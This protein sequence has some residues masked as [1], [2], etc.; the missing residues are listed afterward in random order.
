MKKES[1]NLVQS[2]QF[3]SSTTQDKTISN[4]VLNSGI[5]I[6]NKATLKDTS[7]GDTLLTASILSNEKNHD[8]HEFMQKFDLKDL[9][10][11]TDFNSCSQS[12]LELTKKISWGLDVS[13]I[14]NM[15]M[16]TNSEIVLGDTQNF[17]KTFD[18]SQLKKTF[19]SLKKVDSGNDITD[20][21]NRK[22]LSNS[23]LKGNVQSSFSPNRFSKSPSRFNK[24]DFDRKKSNTK[25]SPVNFSLNKTEKLNQ[26]MNSS[27]LTKDLLNNPESI[28]SEND[29]NSRILTD[30]ILEKQ[31]SFTKTQP[32]QSNSPVKKDNTQNKKPSRRILDI[33]P[34]HVYVDDLVQNSPDNIEELTKA[35][36]NNPRV[37]QT[38]K[39]VD[40]IHHYDTDGFVVIDF[41]QSQNNLNQVMVDSMDFA[42]LKGSLGN[43]SGLKES[44]GNDSGL[45]ES[46]DYSNIIQNINS[47]GKVSDQEKP[48]VFNYATGTDFLGADFNV[49]NVDSEIMDTSDV[50]E[51]RQY[52]CENEDLPNY[53]IPNKS[54]SI[55]VLENF[56]RNLLESE[57]VAA[58][59]NLPSHQTNIP[60]EDENLENSM[61]SGAFKSDRLQK[62]SK[63]EAQK[64][65]Q[66]SL[67]ISKQSGLGITAVDSGVD[68]NFIESN[69][70]NDRVV[71]DSLVNLDAQLINSQVEDNEGFVIVKEQTKKEEKLVQQQK[72]EEE[73]E[74]KFIKEEKNRK[75]QEKKRKEDQEKKR[76]QAEEKK[77]KEDQEKKRKQ[78]DQIQFKLEEEEKKRKIE[79][80]K[81]QKMDEDRQ[82]ADRYQAKQRKIE[83]ED[84]KRKLEE[85]KIRVEE[86]VKKRK[87][88]EE[89][90]RKEDQEK[91]RKLEDEKKRVDEE[92]NHKEEEQKKLKKEE[93][94]KRLEEGVKKRLEEDEKKLNKQREEKKLKKGSP[95][96]KRKA[97]QQN[98]HKDNCNQP[99]NVEYHSKADHAEVEARKVKETNENL[100]RDVEKLEQALEIQR[101]N[102]EEAAQRKKEH[103]DQEKKLAEQEKRKEAEEQKLKEAEK[104]KVQ[105]A[106]EK[107]RQEEVKKQKEVAEQE[108]MRAEEHKRKL[109]DE[110][111]RKNAEAQ[112]R[113][114]A[115]VQKRKNAEAQK[116]KDVEAQKLKDEEAQKRKVEEAQKRMD[117]EAQKRKDE[118]ERKLK[119]AEEEKARKEAE[120]ALKTKKK[121]NKKN[122]QSQKV[123]VAQEESKKTKTPKGNRTPKRSRTPKRNNKTPKN[124]VQDKVEEEV[125]SPLMSN[126]SNHY[127]FN[128]H[129]NPAA[130]VMI[131]QTIVLSVLIV[132]FYLVE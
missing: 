117:E 91:K 86:E 62:K 1:R 131:F 33:L 42:A 83:E 30:S 126:L 79:K 22:R 58:I 54:D 71:F 87:V 39:I 72:T 100:K 7:D 63:A 16:F 110:V 116:R 32:I 56:N 77:L 53:K 106:E 18:T 113:K 73:R 44:L 94:K 26:G 109:A 28:L 49:K 108:R 40:N 6:S 17:S 102:Q 25:P 60:E 104:L 123:S 88:E 95:S 84:K 121:N 93:E 12:Q 132:A 59:N 103:E 90:K 112:K 38:R 114:D 69:L 27:Q 85:E 45:K 128:V 99:V 21:P 111:N 61:Y 52:D 55:D 5:D 43:D 122:T 115:E 24:T 98:K 3:A 118:G 48:Y 107:K 96:N 9:A 92:K 127:G 81:H 15:E 65:S 130:N 35:L 89:K 82:Q 31:E 13:V 101:K 75:E 97:D 10:I 80:E 2:Q 74:K 120:L 29:L 11:S 129:E 125:G 37:G 105:K 36:T 41:D 66:E 67:A 64:K 34:E 51:A 124:Q 8:I 119:A 20:S 47:S 50:I 57:K 4:S 46:F 76:K 14:P 23:Q 70:T 68:V 78:E 19:D